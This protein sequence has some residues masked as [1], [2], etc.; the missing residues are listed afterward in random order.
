MQIKRS[1]KAHWVGAGKDGKGSLTTDSK[2]LDNASYAFHSR[3]ESG[4]GTNPEELIGAAHA[5]CFSMKLAFLFQAAN[6]VPETI[7]TTATVVFE[8]GSIT[9]IFLETFVKAAVDAEQF[10]ALVLDAKENCP[11]S[12]LLNTNIHLQSHLL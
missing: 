7:D 5:G 11:I 6:I 8:N 9:A 1:A 4:A 12:K 3:F 10:N 2:V